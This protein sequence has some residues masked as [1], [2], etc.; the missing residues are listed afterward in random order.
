[1][2][3]KIRSFHAGIAMVAAVL[4][5]LAVPTVGALGGQGP[6]QMGVAVGHSDDPLAV[7]SIQIS[8]CL[9]GPISYEARA[10][11]PLDWKVT[12]KHGPDYGSGY[13][14]HHGTDTLVDVHS[15]NVISAWGYQSATIQFA[16][17]GT[18]QWETLVSAQS[19]N[20]V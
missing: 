13:D 19:P 17:P 3:T 20:C 14:V 7:G 10:D 15:S 8:T 4:A 18:Y 6:G 1:M 2:P 16:E 11:R 9:G 5:L 12:W